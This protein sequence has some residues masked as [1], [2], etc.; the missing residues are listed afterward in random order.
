MGRDKALLELGGRPLALRVADEAAKC[1]GTVSLVG[2]PALYESLGLPV[3]PDTFPGQG[4]LA[5]IEAALG[6]TQAEWNLIAACDMPAL[7]AAV[8][9]QLFNAGG[10]CAV[11]EY[12]DGRVEPLCAVYHRRCHRA[13][14]EAL[15]A[16]VR[17]V[18]EAL[19]RLADGGFALRYVR[20]ASDAQFANLNTPGDMQRYLNG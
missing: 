3:I 10:D 16:G 8:M 12:E 13:V 4:P 11:P 6:A 17:K 19:R 14:R 1:C 2:D 15:E 18:T 9:E 7:G 5:G 20:V